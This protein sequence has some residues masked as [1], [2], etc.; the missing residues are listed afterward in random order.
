MDKETLYNLGSISFNF[1]M[2]AAMLIIAVYIAFALTGEKLFVGDII[3]YASWIGIAL[4]GKLYLKRLRS[5]QRIEG[6]IYALGCLCVI[7]NIAVW[8]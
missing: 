8:F 5:G 3:R 6:Y 7:I 4:A 2:A 1:M